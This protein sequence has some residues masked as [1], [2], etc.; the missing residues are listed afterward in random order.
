MS[1]WGQ[2]GSPWA[3]ASETNS[4]SPLWVCGGEGGREEGLEGTASNWVEPR[5]SL[6]GP[7]MSL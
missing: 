1:C 4:H 5:S 3:G 2:A 7:K 6:N